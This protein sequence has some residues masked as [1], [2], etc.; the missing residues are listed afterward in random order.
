MDVRAAGKRAAQLRQ[1]ISHHDHR[2][3]TLDDPEI[4]DAA[5]DELLTELRALESAHPELVTPDSPTQRV[6]G[7]PAGRF[8]PVTHA[9]P[10]L[11]LDNA[12]SDADVRAFDRRIHERLEHA[13][14]IEYHAEPKLDGLA[15]SLRYRHGELAQAATRGDGTTGEDVTANIRTIRSVPQRLKGHAPAEVEVRGEVYM[16]VAG[17]RELNLR[18]AAAGEKVFANPRNA[19]AG[20]LRQLDPRATAARPLDAYFYA[21]GAWQGVP[22]PDRHAELLDALRHY[23]FRVCEESRLV[24]GVEACLDYYRALGAR[25]ADLPYQIDGVVYKVNDRRWYERLG[26]VSRAPR[27]AIA[28][29]FPADEAMTLLRDVE[30]QVGRTG[31]LTPVARLEPVVVGGA[32]VSNA[33][34]H[35]MDEIERK[36]VRIGDTVVVRRAGDVIPEIVRVERSRRPTHAS[37]V[38][39]PATCPVCGSAVVRTPGEAAARCSGGFVCKA[40]RQEAL[41][42]FVSRRALDIDGLGDKLIAQLVDTGRVRQPSDFWTLDATELAGLDRMGEKSAAKLCA[43]LAAARRTTLPRLIHA[44]GIPDVG[45]ATAAALARHFGSLD[46]LMQADEAALLEVA[47]VGPIIAAKVHGYFADARHRDEI[48]RLRDPA[49]AG[50]VWEESA[51]VRAPAGGPL[52]GLTVVLTGTLAGITRVEAGDRLAALG[53]KVATSVSKKTDYVI[54]GEAAGSKLDKARALGVRVL[55]QAGLEDLLAGRRP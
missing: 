28:H 41:A 7:A 49:I 12:F 6:S 11:S 26:Q 9:V 16:P 10:M 48:A 35:N 19:A 42:H 45:E 3:Y 22:M 39:L 34:L 47:D 37:A 31:V 43:S 30:F 32:T 15:V 4:S 20:S 25:R 51:P 21:V 8:A 13:G 54:A 55:D 27:W 2:Y 18:A 40:Q 50:L 33:T 38:V 44:L 23:G 14:P 1:Q 5:Y 24:I 53:A 46:A 17:F 36:D 52:A 29:K